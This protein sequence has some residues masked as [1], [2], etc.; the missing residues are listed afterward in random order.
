MS[1]PETLADIEIQPIEFATISLDKI[2]ADGAML[3]AYGT[4][5]LAVTAAG[6]DVDLVSLSQST[7]TRPATD[8]EQLQ[9]LKNAQTEW[10]TRAR[11]YDTLASGGTLT[12]PSLTGV[13]ETW[14]ETEGWPWPAQPRDIDAAVE[15]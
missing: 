8:A 11:W 2:A 1:R 3:A 7:F 12:Y 14:A 10:D 13:V 4:F 9:M 15:A 6:A 5:M